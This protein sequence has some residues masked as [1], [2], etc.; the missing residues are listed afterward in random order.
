MA[1]H[2]HLRLRQAG[3]LGHGGVHAFQNLAADPRLGGRGVM[4]TVQFSGSMQA[5]AS[6]GIS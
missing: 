6:S 1:V 3:G 2:R 4:C 5:W